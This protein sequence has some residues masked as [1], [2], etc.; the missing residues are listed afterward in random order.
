[1]KS[2]VSSERSAT[3]WRRCSWLPS[4]PP[5]PRPKVG[6]PNG[7]FNS[8]PR[9]RKGWSGAADRLRRAICRRTPPVAP[10]TASCW[11]R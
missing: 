7:Q 5:L 9:D 10:Y 4:F 6:R 3:S 1:M 2:S 8:D 11:A